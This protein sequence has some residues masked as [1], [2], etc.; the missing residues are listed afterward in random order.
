MIIELGKVV[1]ETKFNGS[2]DEYDNMM[3]G[4]RWP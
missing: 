4:T 1:E 2:S 3:M